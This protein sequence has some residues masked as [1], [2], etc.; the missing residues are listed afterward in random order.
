[1]PGR[2]PRNEH[3]DP[4]KGCVADGTNDDLLDLEGTDDGTDDGTD[5]C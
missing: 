3:L 2:G 5:E 4:H 1:M